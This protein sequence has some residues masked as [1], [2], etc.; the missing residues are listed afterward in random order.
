MSEIKVIDVVV[1]QLQTR[2]CLVFHPVD[3]LDPVQNLSPVP[4]SLSFL[5]IEIILT[6]LVIS[7]WC[8]PS[9]LVNVYIFDIYLE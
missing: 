4:L 6:F 8:K 2:V 1:D 9:I 7:P 5:C 3:L